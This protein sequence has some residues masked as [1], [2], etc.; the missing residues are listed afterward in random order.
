MKPDEL[1]RLLW[2][3][4]DEALD[5]AARERL[6]AA[7]AAEP[8]GE[9]RRQE[10]AECASLL[11]AVEAVPTPPGLRARIDR[12]IAARPTVLP[13]PPCGVWAG[14]LAPRHR[15]H[16]AWAAVL[17]GAIAAGFPADAGVRRE[18]FP[19]SPARCCRVPYP[20]WAP[21]LQSWRTVSA[22]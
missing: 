1:D 8:A 20:S 17:V 3:E 2:D 13:R 16:L 14:V 5:V 18:G 10:V 4:V 11:A 15:M 12:A 22:H 21:R 6:E 7:L 9:R 19:V